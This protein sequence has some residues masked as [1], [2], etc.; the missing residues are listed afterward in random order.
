MTVNFLTNEDQANHKDCCSHRTG[1]IDV[2]M[3]SNT[4]YCTRFGNL[5]KEVLLLTNFPLWH[6][7]LYCIELIRNKMIQIRQGKC[8]GSESLKCTTYTYVCTVYLK[9]TT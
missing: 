5:Y 3:F 1:T 4:Y 2:K 7:K 9:C 8:E 6:F